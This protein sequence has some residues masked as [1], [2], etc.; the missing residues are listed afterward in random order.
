[1]HTAPIAAALAAA[2]ALATA[3]QDLAKVEIK[4]TKVQGGVYML[5]GRGGNIGVSVGDDGIVIV[6]DQFA[7]L[8]PKIVAALKG[9]TDK[10][11]KF[12]INTHWHADHTGGNEAFG[13]TAPV[14][15][16]DNV[17]RRMQEGNARTPPA[18]A[19]ALPVLTFDHQA[20]IHVN[21]EEVRAMH[22]PHGHTDGDAVV[23]FTKSKVVHMGDLFFH[24]M[25]PFIDLDSGGSVKGLI[26]N[27][28]AVA[29]KLDADVKVI[30]GHGPLATVEELKAYS[31]VLKEAVAAV[32]AALREGKTVEQMKAEKLL[33]KHEKLAWSFVTVDRFLET[34][35]R[36]LKPAK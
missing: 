14:V 23:F 22:L 36:D 34:L 4:A 2:G 32:E 13:K 33:A 19:G 35:A 11:V 29:A 6:D 26:A 8:A 20:T 3:A 16:H 1:M 18:P 21:G 17:R 7:P 31:A 15:A 12:V 5:E 30:P 24:G 28:D 10:P 27:V 25:L 9:I